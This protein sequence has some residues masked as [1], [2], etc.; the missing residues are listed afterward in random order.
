[1][2]PIF[3]A[4]PFLTAALHAAPVRAVPGVQ[5]PY[6]FEQNQGQTDPSVRYLARGRGYSLF[7]T[8][9]EA[10]LSLQRSGE[11]PRALR[12]SLSGSRK[13]IAIEPVDVLDQRTN[14]FVGRD[15]R[16]WRRD[17][18]HY[19]RVRYRG[20]YDGIDLVYHSQEGQL[21]YDFVLAPGAS[22][23][24]IGIAKSFGRRRGVAQ[25]L[26]GFLG[27]ASRAHSKQCS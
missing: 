13:P 11:A 7:L 10:V 22:P 1:M 23:D 27:Q 6:T 24:A 4:L 20:V 25:S 14:Y 9:R 15:A 12:M 19:A 17:V 3:L 18:P 2:K 5:L 8:D 21:E 26:S 16:Q